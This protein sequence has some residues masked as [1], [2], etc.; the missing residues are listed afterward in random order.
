[1]QRQ[2]GMVVGGSPPPVTTF[3]VFSF[4]R[5]SRAWAFAQ[6]GMARPLLLNVPGLRFCRMMGAG[7]GLGFTLKPDWG[8]YALLAVWEDEA[9]ARAFLDSS[10]F[11]A[12]YRTRA[13][14]EA[15]AVLRTLAA[16]GAWGGAN[17]FLPATARPEG[18][19][20]PVA[21]LTRA[22]INPLRAGSFWGEVPRVSRRLA[23][24][25][26]LLASIGVGEAPFF[27]QAT[28]SL[29][30]SVEQMKA[31][32]YGTPEHRRVIRRV[33]REGW[34]GEELFARFQVVEATEPFP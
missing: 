6:M 30:R 33:R 7:R 9:H 32:A 34:Y 1:M 10:T 22:A 26:G 20:Q 12:R 16:H 29:W 13:A 5:G 24:A 18:D 31:F 27:L 11:M 19:G 17:P 23:G 3:T 4:D 2:V 21:V 25:P 15:T 8:R 14:R 28:F